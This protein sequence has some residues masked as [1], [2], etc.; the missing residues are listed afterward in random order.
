MMQSFEHHLVDDQIYSARRKR[1]KRR[2]LPCAAAIIT[3]AAATMTRQIF[4]KP[5]KSSARPIPINSV[6]IVNRIED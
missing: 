5:K 4:G 3:G 1:S 6:T 2:K